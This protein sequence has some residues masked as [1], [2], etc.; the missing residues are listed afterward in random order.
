MSD[1]DPDSDW[2]DYKN[3]DR[4]SQ[5]LWFLRGVTET[6]EK[7]VRFDRDATPHAFVDVPERKLCKAET[8]EQLL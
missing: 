4:V 7:R 2:F 1:G 6:V 5:K 3:D 8:L